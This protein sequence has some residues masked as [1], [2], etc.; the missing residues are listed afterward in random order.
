[1]FAL[2][3]KIYSSDIE[4]AQRKTCKTYSY[5]DKTQIQLAHTCHSLRDFMFYANKEIVIDQVEFNKSFWNKLSKM[6]LKFHFN[7]LL[8]NFILSEEKNSSQLCSTM[9]YHFYTINLYYLNPFQ[10]HSIPPEFK[11]NIRII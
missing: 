7:Y 9:K 3:L 1:M 10:T 4:K 11:A 2:Y 8:D 6:V 5:Y